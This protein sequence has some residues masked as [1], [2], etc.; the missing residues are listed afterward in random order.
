MIP[1]F[2]HAWSGCR[3]STLVYHIDTHGSAPLGTKPAALFTFFLSVL[4][5]D[6]HNLLGSVQKKHSVKGMR[7]LMGFGILVEFGSR[8]GVVARDWFVVP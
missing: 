4:K 7:G 5:P 8:V 2:S 1:H 6:V 3:S